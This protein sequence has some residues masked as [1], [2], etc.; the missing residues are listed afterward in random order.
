MLCNVFWRLMHN[1]FE[2]L[3][4]IWH[5]TGKVFSISQA[6]FGFSLIWRHRGCCLSAELLTTVFDLETSKLCGKVNSLSPVDA[7]QTYLDML[8]NFS[9]E[10]IFNFYST[11]QNF[12][13][14]KDRNVEFYCETTVYL[15]LDPFMHQIL[16]L[17]VPTNSFDKLFCNDN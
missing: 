2:W 5:L 7:H 3:Q 11:S 12:T 14:D 1:S 9:T 17:Y 13:L 8:N 16:D 15:V 4:F 6:S 10:T